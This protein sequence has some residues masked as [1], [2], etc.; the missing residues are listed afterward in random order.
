LAGVTVQLQDD[1]GNVVATTV[2]N[3]RGDYSFNQLN[4]VS[5][6]GNYTVR[7]VVPSGDTQTSANP[8]TILISRGD[9]DVSGVDFVVAQSSQDTVSPGRRQDPSAPHHF[10]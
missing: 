10:V 9:L 4:G 6:T 5:A 7:I 2:T 3:S 1:S 8:S